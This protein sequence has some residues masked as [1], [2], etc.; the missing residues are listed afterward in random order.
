MIPGIHKW[1]DDKVGKNLNEHKKTVNL[2]FS[3]RAEFSIG[4]VVGNRETVGLGKEAFPVF[5]GCV[6][7]ECVSSEI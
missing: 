3:S 4:G 1:R 2:F 7:V 6:T 5:P